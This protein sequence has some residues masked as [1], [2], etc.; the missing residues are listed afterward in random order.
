MANFFLVCGMSGGG[1][2]ILSEH[3]QEHNKDKDIVYLDVDQ[4]YA[5]VY[6]DE[7]IRGD[8]WPVW[9][10]LWN[11]LHEYEIHNQDVLLTTNALYEA[12]RNQFIEWF[13]TFTHHMIWVD[14][15]KERCFEGN[16]QR[17]RHVPDATMERFWQDM[18]FP[19][20]SERGWDTI[21]KITNWWLPEYSV[22]NIKGNIK[23]Y[24]YIKEGNRKSYE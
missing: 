4:Y 2:T 12:Q 18:E 9:M 16:R 8:F 11:D 6:G 1:K 10:L 19:D 5:R 20:A 14:A 3:I 23:D 21:C 7:C 24:L 22:Y 15:P 17:R 13:P